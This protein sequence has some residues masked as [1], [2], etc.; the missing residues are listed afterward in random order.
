MVDQFFDGKAGPEAK[1]V[2]RIDSSHDEGANTWFTVV[3]SKRHK[4]A[5]YQEKEGIRK[6]VQYQIEI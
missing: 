4:F 1:R 5:K 6:V 2:E 3:L